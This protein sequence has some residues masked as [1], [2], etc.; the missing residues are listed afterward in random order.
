MT[1]LLGAEV[2][3]IFIQTRRY[4]FEFAS[5]TIVLVMVFLGLFVGASYLAGVPIRGPHLS[6]VV[7]GY[8]AWMLAMTATSD[9]GFD[10]QNEAQNGTLEQLFLT[11]RPTGLVMLVRDVVSVTFYM[12]PM[13]VVLVVVVLVTGAR[14]TVSPL[15]LVPTALALATA[16][17]LG[18][19]IASGAILFKRMNQVLN[20]VQFLLLFV[21][22]A[23]I[24]QL[25]GMWHVAATILPL[26]PSVGLLDHLTIPGGGAG[27]AVLLIEACANAALWLGAGLWLFARA[28]RLA[29]DRAI[30]AHY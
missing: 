12:V 19:V 30:L 4:P 5:G 8:M 14:F 15:D 25:G 28:D 3:R 13:A 9:M 22:M 7:L 2:R 21:V 1:G 27:T 16:W 6:D 24:A 20:L 26:S 10:L 17:G 23:P 29:R 11:P 18:L